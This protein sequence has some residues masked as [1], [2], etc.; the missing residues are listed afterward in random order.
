MASL[1]LA[2]KTDLASIPAEIPYLKAS[3]ELVTQWRGMLAEK[4]G[5]RVGIVW[6][7]NPD[8]NNDRN[9]SMSL[10]DLMPL[11]DTGVELISLQKDMN[12]TDRIMLGALPIKDIGSKL[13][14]FSDTAAVIASLDLVISVCTSVAHLA[15]AMGKPLWILLS[16]TACW[17][18]L[19]EREHSPWYPTARLFRQNSMGNWKDVIQNVA[20]ELRKLDIR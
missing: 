12:H 9:R 19:L 17:R 20:D 5:L 1:P 18:W 7:G 15:G 11:M 2:F 3:D 14:N 4:R 13:Q 8:Q 16:H 10:F 6:A